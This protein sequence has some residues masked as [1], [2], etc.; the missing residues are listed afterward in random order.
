MA[1]QT[2]AQAR[3]EFTI[4]FGWNDRA[5]APGDL[6]GG[7]GPVT[8]QTASPRAWPGVELFDPASGTLVSS[9]HPVLPDR[10]DADRGGGQTDVWARIRGL[11]GRRDEDGQ[12]LVEYGLILALITLVAIFS[13][14]S[15]GV[16]MNEIFMRVADSLTSVS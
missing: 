5:P 16:K 4:T 3:G 11:S 13:L 1:I 8:T 12:G 14:S 7:A 15:P 2:A 6:P 10:G 9:L